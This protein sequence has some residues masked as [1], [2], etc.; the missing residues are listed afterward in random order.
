VVDSVLHSIP[1]SGFERMK[2]TSAG[3]SNFLHDGG[4]CVF[5]MFIVSFIDEYEDY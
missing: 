1:L 2:C 5:F 4:A 3:R